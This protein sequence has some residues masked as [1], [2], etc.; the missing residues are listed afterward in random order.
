METRLDAIKLGKSPFIRLRHSL[1]C[2]RDAPLTSARSVIG[3]WETRRIP[4]NLIVGSAGIL[5]CIIIGIVALG[6]SLLFES[7]F[8]SPGYPFLTL[9]AILIYGIMANIC[10]TGGWL[11]EL[12]LRRIWPSETD[13]F[14]ILSFSAGLV[15]SVLLTLAPGILIGCA[16]IFGLLGH[17]PVRSLLLQ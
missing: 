2:T 1:L 8:G 16:G 14:A 15:F 13:K 5:S 12:L 9:F 10:F 11:L 6:S 4:F 7:D 17:F 3:W